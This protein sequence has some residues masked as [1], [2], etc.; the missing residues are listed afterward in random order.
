MS[1][2]VS[3]TVGAANER[4]SGQRF[5]VSASEKEVRFKGGKRGDTGLPASA[6][7][8]PTGGYSSTLTRVM[9]ALSLCPAVTPSDRL[10]GKRETN[11]ALFPSPCRPLWGSVLLRVSLLE[12]RL[13]RGT[14]HR[15]G[16]ACCMPA[17][18]WLSL[19]PF[20]F[21][22]LRFSLLII[23]LRK[24]CC[25]PQPSQLFSFR[26]P[27]DRGNRKAAAARAAMTPKVYVGVRQYIYGNYMTVSFAV[28][29]VKKKTT[30]EFLCTAVPPPSS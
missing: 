28:F 11:P 9:T 15:S 17:A 6:S 20:C 24:L 26:T 25:P 22:F 30:F 23:S 16:S 29:S 13:L 1:R 5:T 10:F 21:S 4:G 27:V 18:S 2:C 3:S 19:S 8:S 7:P 12:R 14:H